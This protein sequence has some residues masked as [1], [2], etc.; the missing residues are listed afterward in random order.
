[1][2][3]HPLACLE[4]FLEKHLTEKRSLPS[5]QKLLELFKKNFSRKMWS[6][7]AMFK[8]RNNSAPKMDFWC[9]LRCTE[10]CASILA[11][12]VDRFVCVHFQRVEVEQ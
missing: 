6:A 3:T 12:P 5:Y 8:V 11:K 10:D 1:M 9:L 2:S 4:R 7:V